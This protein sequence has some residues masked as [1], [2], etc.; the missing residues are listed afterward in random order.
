[1]SRGPTMFKIGGV[2]VNDNDE[3]F[4]IEAN[5]DDYDTWI[6]GSTAGAMDVFVS[7]DGTN[8]LTTAVALID[9]N[10]TAPSTAVVVTAA[11]RHYGVKGRFKKVRVLQNGATGIAN[12]TLIGYNV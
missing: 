1:M 6:L 3:I 10:S 8:Y 5:A 7:L 4:E 2:G 12:G 9:L 11:Q